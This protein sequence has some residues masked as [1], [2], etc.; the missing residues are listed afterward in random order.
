MGW[1]HSSRIEARFALAAAEEAA[2]SRRGR[3]GRGCQVTDRPAC[4]T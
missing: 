3:G 4:R 1:V 2:N